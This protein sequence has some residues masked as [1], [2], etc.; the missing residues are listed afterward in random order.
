MMQCEEI[1]LSMCMLFF[2]DLTLANFNRTTVFLSP[3]FTGPRIF[4]SEDVAEKLII[5]N[6]FH[7]K[8]NTITKDKN[9]N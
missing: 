5:C 9:M 4:F 8:N 7:F 2:A 6:P 1:F 3:F